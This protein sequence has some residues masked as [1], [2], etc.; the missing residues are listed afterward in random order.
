MSA[1]GAPLLWAVASRPK[2]GEVVAGDVYRVRELDDGVLVV[3]I[4]GIGH[5][6]AA[7]AAADTAA[8]AAMTAAVTPL[9]ALV[10]QCHAAAK[11]TRGCVMSVAHVSDGSIEWIGVGNVEGVVRKYDAGSRERLLNLGGIVGE[12]LPKALAR[13]VPLVRGDVLVLATDGAPGA[14]LDEQL[15]F[16]EPQRAA[17][18][19][20]KRHATGADDAL[21][22]VGRYV[23]GG[24][25]GVRGG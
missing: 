9:F 24:G 3:V 22:F 18:E 23:G 1:R 13:T 25:E 12:R 17:D 2:S 4:D 16:T 20:L 8:D 15:P 21:V 7:R 14:V 19:L 6:P 10:E 11:K 5:G